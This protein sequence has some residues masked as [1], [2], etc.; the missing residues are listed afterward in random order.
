MSNLLEQASLV[1]IP[2]GYKEDVVYSEIPL[3][4]A[5]DMAFTRS[6]NGTRINSAGLVEVCPWNM[7]GY[8]EDFSNAY[9]TKNNIPVMA[10][11]V[12]TAPN[13]TMT[14]DSIKSDSSSVYQSV[15]ATTITVAANSTVTLSIYIK[16]ET[17][18]TYFTGSYL[19]F[20]GGTT[21]LTYVLFDEVNGTINILAPDQVSMV[22]SVESVGDWWR[23]IVT[24]TDTGSNTNLDFAFYGT[25]SQNGTS[26]SPGIGSARTIWG[27][28]LNI[29]S[30]AKPYFPTTD[31][32]NVPRLTYQ[33]GGGGCPSLLLEKQSTNVV[34][35]SEDFSNASWLT[36][37]VTL[38]ANQTTSPDGT[39]NADSLIPNTTNT[40]IHRI[41][42]SAINSIATASYSIFVKPNGY[43]R[44]ALR[45]CETTGSSIGFDLLNETI[46]TTYSTGGCTASGGKIENM[47]NGWYRISGIFSFASATSQ[48]LGLYVVSSSWTSGDPE[49]VS[50]AGNGTSG[51]YLY[52]AQM[53]AS[54]YPTSYIPTTSSSATRVADACSKTGI[55]SLIGQ[56]EGTMF[57]QVTAKYK[58]ADIASINTGTTNAIY[59]VKTSNNYYRATIYA[60]GVAVV[61]ITQ[62][63][64]IETSAKIAVV[65]KSGSTSLFVNGSKIGA[66][67]TTYTFTT[68]LNSFYLQPNYL[69]GFETN[70]VQQSC[71]F[72]TALTDA[73]CQALTTL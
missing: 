52:G 36:S 7:A 6:S 43:Y 19:Y 70:E 39:Q 11:N 66:N 10:Y 44:V 21:K 72:P 2:S 22:T 42:E 14:A 34:L 3:D 25:L 27:A 8:S 47:G 56:T 63:A 61:T 35:N 33:N 40:T 20:T 30:T 57:V 32:L 29:G 17:S 68:A 13:G 4:G 64:V 65:Y 38:T 37:N 69:V 58:N 5:G 41:F 48:R 1:L 60:G 62:G 45:E 54:S 15:S 73:E 49:S 18:K 26:L 71:L 67:T 9:W 46:I 28:Q 59:I 50:W 24:G 12:A 53:E 23:F 31:R 55:S 16:K 51:V